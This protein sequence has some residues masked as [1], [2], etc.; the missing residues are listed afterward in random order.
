M[1]WDVIIIGAGVNGLTT[2]T[3]LAR[4]GKRVLVV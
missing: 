4:A 2:A 3:V 1:S